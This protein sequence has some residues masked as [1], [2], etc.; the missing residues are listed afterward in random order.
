MAFFLD[1]A[2]FAYATIVTGMFYLMVRRHIA[3]QTT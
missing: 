3:M 1:L 2:F